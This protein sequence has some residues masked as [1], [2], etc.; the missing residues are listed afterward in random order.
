[1]QEHLEMTGKQ[2]CWSDS[3]IFLSVQT[4]RYKQTDRQAD[5]H[6]HTHTH[7]YG[8]G[9]GRGREGEGEGGDCP[10]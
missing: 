7:I 8:E 3:G 4:H 6:T 1:M 2:M 5:R 9:E 10:A